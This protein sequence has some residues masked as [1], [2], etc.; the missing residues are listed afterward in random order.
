VFSITTIVKQKLIGIFSECF[1]IRIHPSFKNEKFPDHA[2]IFG[3]MKV[4]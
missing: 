4:F 1:P 3:E 2:Q